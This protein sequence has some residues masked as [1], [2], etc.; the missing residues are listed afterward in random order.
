MNRV[1]LVDVIAEE[2]GFP[3][4]FV[5]QVVREFE[6]QVGQTMHKGESVVLRGFGKFEP[7]VRKARMGVNPRNPEE[8]IEI[9]ETV[10]PVFKAGKLLKDIVA[11]KIL[12]AT[13]KQI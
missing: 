12:S 2:L 11:G 6:H 4:V 1:E 8:R 9:P 5:D 3:K 13:I 10:A 7:R